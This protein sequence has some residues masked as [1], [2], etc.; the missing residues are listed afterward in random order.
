MARRSSRRG[1]PHRGG[2][3]GYE[4][5]ARILGRELRAVELAIEGHS[6][7]AIATELGV[8][9]AAVSKILKRADERALVE[10]TERIERHKVRQSQRLERLYVESTRAWEKSKADT[11]KRRQRKSGT[12]GGDSD[13]GQT[14][15]EIV[16]ETRHGDPR[17][18]EVCRKALADLRKIW[19]LDA[20][21]QVDVLNHDGLEH[22]TE[23]EL[24]DR[25]RRQDAL[26][27]RAEADRR[28]SL[29]PSKE[30]Q[31]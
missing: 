20:P 27:R 15:A 25:L 26:L 4:P 12:E 24:L 8:S 10:I 28:P 19:G 30:S 7:H 5:R 23:P 14:V 9:Q 6:Q 1:R 21:Q 11:T 31:R 17:Y 22:L 16:V 29:K 2:Q 18:L 13:P 3:G